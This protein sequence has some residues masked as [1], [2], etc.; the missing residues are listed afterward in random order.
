M[1]NDE[2]NIKKIIDPTIKKINIDK[3]TG[4]KL[5]LDQMVQK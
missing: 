1:Q 4:K 5:T 2:S 3:K